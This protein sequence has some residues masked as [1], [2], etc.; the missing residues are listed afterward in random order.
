MGQ[1][2]GF[3][4]DGTA[5]NETSASFSKMLRPTA[6]VLQAASRSFNAAARC[7]SLVSRSVSSASMLTTTCLAT[8]ANDRAAQLETHAVR[9]C[10][11]RSDA[12]SMLELEPREPSRLLSD[13]PVGYCPLFLS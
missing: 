9:A 13:S 11:Q 12:R 5:A 6:P 4:R 8:E 1:G 10:L 7:C 3:S 2:S